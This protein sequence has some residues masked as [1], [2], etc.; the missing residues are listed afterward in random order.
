MCNFEATVAAYASAAD[1]GEK[2]GCVCSYCRNFFAQVDKIY[3]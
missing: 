2:G 3:N 1:W